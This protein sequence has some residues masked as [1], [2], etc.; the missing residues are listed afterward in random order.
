[1]QYNQ[2]L[3]KNAANYMQLSPLS[4]IKRAAY[5]YPDKESLVYKSRRFTWKETY[6]RSCQLAHAL[7]QKGIKEGDTVSVMGFNTPETYEA[8]FG[9]PMSGAVLH[10]INTRLDA[11][12]IAFM[13]DHAETKILLTDRAASEIIKE[14][15]TIVKFKPIVIDIIDENVPEGEPLGESSYDEFIASGDPQF[16]WSMP[17]DEWNAISLNYT[18]GTTGNPKGVVYHHRGAHLNAMA[19]VLGWGLPKHFVY[20]W[21]LPMFHCN[22]WCFPWTL[23]ALGGKSV[24]L[25]AVRVDDIFQSISNESVTH[26]CG[27]PIVLSTIA[28]ASDKLKSLLTHRVKG[29][30]GGAPPPAAVLNAM[31]ECGFDITHT[32][33]LTEVYGPSTFCDWNEDWNKL[34]ERDQDYLKSSQGVSNHVSE[35]VR[36]VNSES[37]EDVPP[38]GESIGEILFRGHNTMKGYLKNPA[39]NEKAFKGGW[40]HSGDLAVLMPNGYVKIKDRSKDIIISGGEN[41]SSIEIEG[42][43]FR[44]PAVMDAAV[45]AKSDEKWGEVP[46]AFVHLKDSQLVKEEELIKFVK[47]E[48]AHFKAPKYILFGPLPKTATGKTQKFVLRE[49]AE[50]VMH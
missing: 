19:N 50:Q 25:R 48:L 2:G 35:M 5:V 23:A 26:F 21:T 7:I 4:F 13:M 8:H 41:I 39:A 16:N 18:S 45:V 42:A 20:L 31:E 47:S 34:P 36:I 14:A 17:S 49:K 15:L 22:G 10:A 29:L 46:C 43:L 33:G 32:Y 12:S 37:G 38:D 28:N 40:F 9:V 30:T 24:C 1:M 27:A 11:K 3:D 44:H 6:E